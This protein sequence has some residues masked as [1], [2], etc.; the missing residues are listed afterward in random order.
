MPTKDY[1]KRWRL[2]EARCALTNAEVESIDEVRRIYGFNS[3][4]QFAADYLAVMGEKPSD[5][6]KRGKQEAG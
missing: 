3:R 1:F 5:T 4:N 2:E 6:L